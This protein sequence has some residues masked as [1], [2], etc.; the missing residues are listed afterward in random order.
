MADSHQY[1]FKT[2]L[3]SSHPGKKGPAFGAINIPLNFTRPFQ[4]FKLLMDLDISER[5]VDST[6]DFATNKGVN[7]WN[8]LTIA[9]FYSF[10]AILLFMG[11]NQR[12]KVRNYFS[13]NPTLDTK[14][15]K[16]RMSRNE[17]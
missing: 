5:F 1:H 6:N 16:F 8:T 15:V 7:S 11:A 2:V 4:F 9:G 13:K 3:E 10:C 14:F 17:F 12:P